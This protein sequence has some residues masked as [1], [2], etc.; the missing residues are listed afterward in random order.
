MDYQQI[1]NDIEIEIQPLYFL[2]GV[3]TTLELQNNFFPSRVYQK[4][5]HLL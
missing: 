2:M 1:I 4:Y 5:L 3:F